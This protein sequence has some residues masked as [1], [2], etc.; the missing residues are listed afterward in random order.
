MKVLDA[1]VI[2]NFYTNIKR[3]DLLLK[4]SE[5]GHDLI[6]PSQVF[7]EISS[8]KSIL[9]IKEHVSAGKINVKEEDDISD[10]ERRHPNLGKGELS[11]IKLA[12]DA[13][14][15]SE[16]YCCFDDQK[17][18][19]VARAFGLKTVESWDMVKALAAK[20]IICPSELSEMK[21]TFQSLFKR[22]F[23]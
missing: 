12:L 5:L 10:L 15:K 6:C 11:V 13:V 8:D 3:S 1:C 16:V 22:V 20:G 21:K 7:E 19:K 4:W 17:A 14:N 23:K 9:L 18:K 2:I